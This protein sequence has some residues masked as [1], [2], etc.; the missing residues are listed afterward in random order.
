[1]LKIQRCVI[2]LIGWQKS[3]SAPFARKLNPKN[4]VGP[5]FFILPRLKTNQVASFVKPKGSGIV[6]N[7]SSRWLSH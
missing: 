6:L 5:Y 2:L 1:M 4:T 7:H 3:S